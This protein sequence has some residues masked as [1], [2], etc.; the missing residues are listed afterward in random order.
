MLSHPDSCYKVGNSPTE[1]HLTDLKHRAELSGRDDADILRDMMSHISESI[2][3]FPQL[4]QREKS[5][6]ITHLIDLKLNIIL[7]KSHHEELT[8]HL[9]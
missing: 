7:F 5:S 8:R 6:T 9:T 3:L 1:S 4:P 2:T